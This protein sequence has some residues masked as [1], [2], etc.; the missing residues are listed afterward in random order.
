MRTPDNKP[1][2]NCHT[3]RRIGWLWAIIALST[4]STMSY[5]DEG[6]GH[7]QQPQAAQSD[8]V[9]EMC[10]VMTENKIDPGIYT[11]YQGKKV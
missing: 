10:P 1:T 4:L 11:E 2:G 9:Q 6:H 5:A 8:I 3:S 7:D